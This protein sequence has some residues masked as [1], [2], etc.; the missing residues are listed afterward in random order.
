MKEGNW[1]GMEI[2]NH[3][4]KSTEIFDPV[5]LKSAVKQVSHLFRPSGSGFFIYDLIREKTTLV[6]THNLTEITWDEGLPDRVISSQ[7]T[8][9]ETCLKGFAVLAVP[10]IWRYAARG[11]LVVVAKEPKRIFNDRD[12]ALLQSMA[13]LAASVLQQAERLSRMTAQFRALHE[14][15]IALTSSLQLGR[16]L[17]LILEKAVELVWAE[18]G[19]LR[20]LNPETGELDLKAHLGAGWTPDA[21]AFNPKRGIVRWVA[22]HRRSYLCPDVRQD[23]Q[24]VVLFEDM[25]SSVAVPLLYSKDKQQKEDELLG[26][27]LLES[28]RLSAFDQQDVELLEALAKEAVIA[29]QNATQHQ[30]LRL[31]H[32]KLQAEQERRLAAEKWTVMGQAAT[33]LAHRINNLMGIVPASAGEIHRTMAGLDIKKTDR[34]WIEENLGRVE[35]NAQFILKLSDALF[36]P[37]K[38]SGLPSMF[39]ANRLLNE[40]L[41]SIDL[42]PTIHLVRDYSQDLPL[43]ES[44]SLLIDIF[45]ELF[46][47]ARKAMDDSAKKRLLLQTR[48]ESDESGLWVVVRISDTGS[49]ISAE[50]M[51]HLWD[52]FQ[53]SAN[54]IGFGLWWIRTFIERQGGTIV[55]ES[56]PGEGTTFTV[57][58]PA[59]SGEE[60]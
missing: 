10:L 30:E 52:I 27:L 11:V 14:I 50:R 19:S 5:F 13:E 54:G 15:D 42:P 3:D 16:L 56:K 4:L 31:M 1:A 37:F 26:V 48:V 46:T 57:R 39:D 49:G 32:Q 6:A 2:M 43:V 28:A 21:R 24:N 58:L 41:E 25:R 36:R 20:R 34:D 8:T 22:E 38:E 45:L 40:A 33:A 9:V 29:I 55:C 7:K 35:R 59:Y 53:Q 47:N 23:P 12:V 44:S 17:D 60:S 51:V 18:H